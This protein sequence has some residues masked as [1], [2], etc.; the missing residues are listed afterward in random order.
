MSS[1]FGCV[2]LLAL[3]AFYFCALLIVIISVGI[4]HAM[5]Q[6]SDS[7][8]SSVT[9]PLDIFIFVVAMDACVFVGF[10]TAIVRKSVGQCGNAIIGFTAVFTVYYLFTA[11]GFITSTNQTVKALLVGLFLRTIVNILLIIAL[12]VNWPFTNGHKCTRQSA[13]VVEMCSAPVGST[14]STKVLSDSKPVDLEEGKVVEEDRA[15]T[16]A[17]LA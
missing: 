9:A 7:A 14:E 8:D 3:A 12:G 4:L 10:L 16:P 17:T 1:K 5:I 2:A 6:S 15:E 13:N 11:S